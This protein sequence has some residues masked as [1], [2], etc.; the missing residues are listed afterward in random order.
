M[1]GTDDREKPRV[2]SSVWTR[3]VG[4]RRSLR[5][6][7]VL[8]GSGHPAFSTKHMHGSYAIRALNDY[9]VIRQHKNI[10]NLELILLTLTS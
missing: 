5:T 9:T 1:D 3:Q 2:D 10:P 6:N 8:S 7:A 4:S